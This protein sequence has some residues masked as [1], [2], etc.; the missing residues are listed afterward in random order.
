MNAPIGRNDDLIALP[1][2]GM[3][4]AN[5]LAMMLNQYEGVRQLRLIQEQLDQFR[6]ELVL[7]DGYPQ[8]LYHRMRGHIRG[9]VGAPIEVQVERVDS[10]PSEKLKY[11]WFHQTFRN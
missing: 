9:Y 7:L 8:D 11:R 2:G 6:L 1:G 10:I 5:G 4:S 3:R